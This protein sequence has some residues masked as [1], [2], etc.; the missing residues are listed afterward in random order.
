MAKN[1]VYKNTAPLPATAISLIRN[2]L[3]MNGKPITEIT[4]I[5]NGV[6]AVVH[7]TLTAQAEKIV[8][9]ARYFFRGSVPILEPNKWRADNNDAAIKN[10]N[11]AS[12]TTARL[13]MMERLSN[14]CAIA[15]IK[16]AG[17]DNPNALDIK[18][19]VGDVNAPNKAEVKRRG[20]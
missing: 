18:N 8:V 9:A 13:S 4:A 20:T 11:C 14:V 6:T 5:N 15:G 3:F 12:I 19:R 2:D 7:L 10:V 17:I 1:N 16:L